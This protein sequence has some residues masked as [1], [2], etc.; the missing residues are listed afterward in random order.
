MYDDLMT[1]TIELPLSSAYSAISENFFYV[2][3]IA[4]TL[5]QNPGMASQAIGFVSIYSD[6]FVSESSSDLL[7]RCNYNAIPDDILDARVGYIE[8]FGLSITFMSQL[9]HTQLADSRSCHLAGKFFNIPHL[10]YS[11]IAYHRTRAESVNCLIMFHNFNRATP[12]DHV[13]VNATFD[14]YYT[15]NN[16]LPIGND[17]CTGLEQAK[18][19]AARSVEDGFDD[20][21]DS[22]YDPRYRNPYHRVIL[23]NETI[24]ILRQM[25]KTLN[26]PKARARIVDV[27]NYEGIPL[28]V[29]NKRWD[30]SAVCGWPLISSSAKLLG[31]ECNL[32]PEVDSIRNALETTQ[33]LIN[34]NAGQLTDL[35]KDL[36]MTNG[37]IK[38]IYD[39]LTT[40]AEN[41]NFISSK[42][43]ML[44]FELY[45]QRLQHQRSTYALNFATLL[46]KI[47][48][49]RLSEMSGARMEGDTLLN[50]GVL[51]AKHNASLSSM[52]STYVMITG[53]TFKDMKFGVSNVHID[54]S[55]P[56]LYNDRSPLRALA[57][58]AY[59]FPVCYND[60]L[61]TYQGISHHELLCTKDFECFQYPTSMCYT[62][63]VGS[64]LCPTDIPIPPQRVNHGV[65]KSSHNCRAS[66]KIPPRTLYFAY[67]AMLT[68]TSCISDDVRHHEIKAP[69]VFDMMCGYTYTHKHNA[70]SYNYDNC[71]CTAN[72]QFVY[73]YN[74]GIITPRSY[75]VDHKLSGTWIYNRPFHIHNQLHDINQQANNFD[76]TNIRQHIDKLV[77]EHRAINSMLEH[78]IQGIHGTVD[79][80]TSIIIAAVVIVFTLALFYCLCR[81][82]PYARL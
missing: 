54:V 2:S 36:L 48:A 52:R 4:S 5:W 44:E 49:M 51:L 63:A 15:F 53:V 79:G 8:K 70:T 64:L 35:Y 66:Y 43:L 80:W 28:E 65:I 76:D 68:V 62:S 23:N 18:H 13:P 17:M 67:D 73:D 32:S 57:F 19:R 40:N 71:Y 30:S 41:V 16:I 7:N 58:S 77:V 14:E 37:A 56:I 69:M 34:N 42:V 29:R 50:L 11:Y 72:E 78:Q 6:R 74:D 25:M 55:I 31:G 27:F 3:T 75:T 45:W 47:N 46:A 1:R 33:S 21:D 22:D 26:D 24:P 81:V 39:D 9:L 38:H 82:N 59:S 10:F 12:V 20:N 60:M 61:T